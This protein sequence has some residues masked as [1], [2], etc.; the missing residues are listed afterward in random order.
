M[1]TRKKKKQ[2]HDHQNQNIDNQSS[3][4]KNRPRN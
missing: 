2:T 3:W 4:G 1:F